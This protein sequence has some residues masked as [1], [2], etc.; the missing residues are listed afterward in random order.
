[1]T[2]KTQSQIL[3]E[4]QNGLH[5]SSIKAMD[6]YL[7]YLQELKVHSDELEKLEF[8]S[9]YGTTALLQMSAVT[10]TLGKQIFELESSLNRFSETTTKLTHVLI[11]LAGLQI[12][13]V[14]L[15]VGRMFN[16]F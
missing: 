10:S 6:G 16:F 4:L 8:T 2:K 11:V 1:M 9:A 5:D 3:A 7:K 15:Q 12:V 13:L 14:V